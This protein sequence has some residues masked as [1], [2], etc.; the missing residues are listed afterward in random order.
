MTVVPGQTVDTEFSPH[1]T[2]GR[3]SV[4]T[5]LAG[6][7]LTRSM[8]V[9]ISAGPT[10][11][12]TLHLETQA[13]DAWHVPSH[14]LAAWSG[15]PGEGHWRPEASREPPISV[16]TSPNTRWRNYWY[17]G[18]GPSQHL[19]V[20]DRL[21]LSF[22]RPHRLSRHGPGSPV[23]PSFTPCASTHALPLRFPLIDNIIFTVF[24]YPFSGWNRT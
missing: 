7:P 24:P 1:D 21:K 9:P 22:R 18:H 8:P 4:W 15:S 10:G 11:R 2:V 23:E 20:A 17:G 19:F 14:C 5:V 16:G 6:T 13:N 12:S 3:R